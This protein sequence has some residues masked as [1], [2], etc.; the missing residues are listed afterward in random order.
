MPVAERVPKKKPERDS[1]GRKAKT[2]LLVD[3]MRRAI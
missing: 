1:H 3:T 2:S